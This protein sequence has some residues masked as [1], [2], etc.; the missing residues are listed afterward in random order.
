LYDRLISAI[1]AVPGVRSA[2]LSAMPLI[3]S[4]EWDGLVLADGTGKERTVFIQAV[5]WN[6]A[7]NASPVNQRRESEPI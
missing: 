1:E 3:G 2:T 4:R 6:F 5:R 7:V